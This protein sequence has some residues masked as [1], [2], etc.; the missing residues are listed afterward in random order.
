MDSRMELFRQLDFVRMGGMT[1][2]YHTKNV[3]KENTVGAHSFGVAWML[4]FITNGECSANLLMAGLAHDLA[5]HVT[6]DISSPTKRKFPALAE[7][8][9][10]MEHDLLSQ[11]NV[12]FEFDLSPEELRSLK[13]ADCMDGAIYCVGERELGNIS[14]MPIWTR[15]CE[16]IESLKPTSREWVVYAAIRLM[17]REHGGEI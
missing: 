8:V 10:T 17:M 2:R 1:K 15:Y 16:Y 6:G 12:N 4:W 7:M 3:I 14:I 13:L 11:H 9:Q 5:E